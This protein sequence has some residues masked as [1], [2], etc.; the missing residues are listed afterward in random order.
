[1]KL[2]AGK[3]KLWKVFGLVHLIAIIL[4]LIYCVRTESFVKLELWSDQSYKVIAETPMGKELRYSNTSGDTLRLNL[5]PW[6]S[7][8][9][10]IAGDEQALSVDDDNVTKHKLSF[11]T[12][13][14]HYKMQFPSKNPMISIALFLINVLP[15][16][17]VYFLLLLLFFIIGIYRKSNGFKKINWLKQQLFR[18]IANGKEDL[19]S[20]PLKPLS[21]RIYQK[22]ILIA[23]IIVLIPVF[24]LNLGK[25]SFSQ[26]PEE[27]RRALVSLEMKM[28]GEYIIPTIQGEPYYKKPP[29]FNWL[30]IPFVDGDNPEGACRSV[31][32]SLLLL[33]GLV[34]FFL[35]KKHRGWQHALFVVFMYLSSM[36]VTRYL[37]F[38]L[39]LD[40]LFV[41]FL[42]PLIYLNFRYASSGR[43]YRLFIF[44]YALTSLAFLTKGIPALWV[45]FVSLMIALIINKKLKY[46]FSLPHLYGIFVLLLIIGGYFG[47]YSMQS[48]LLPYLKQFVAETLVVDMFSFKEIVAHCIS[49]PGLNMAAFMPL[50]LF[51]PLV[52]LKEN[53]HRILKSKKLSYLLLTTIAGVSVF[54]V[55]PYY[56]PYYSLMFVPVMFDVL[57]VLL[58]DFTSG[59]WKKALRA[60]LI[61]VVLIIPGF[62][63]GYINTWLVLIIGLGIYCLWRQSIN[64]LLI[65]GFVL[66]FWKGVGDMR[67][68]SDTENFILPTKEKCKQIVQDNP[69]IKLKTY[70]QETKVN[71][72]TLYYLTYFSGDIVP[73]SN[74]KPENDVYYL[75]E[76]KDM[77]EKHV[78]SDTIPQLYWTFDG[79]ERLN[80]RSKYHPVYVV[81]FKQKE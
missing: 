68:Y 29:L 62:I 37:S 5:R 66:V 20:K 70:S 11:S 71:H 10:S 17:Q 12:G 32:V 33:G 55:S 35:L 46:L 78:V 43:Y 56:L 1:M 6:K 7:I 13:D 42:V 48:D 31:S 58:P 63:T 34:I 60:Y 67:Y 51:L 69:D 28:R 25:Y 50:A 8:Q 80:G 19:S 2:F 24:Y 79:D 40:V 22:V 61:F 59:T 65:S 14:L 52:L 23:G 72:V 30:L 45:Q 36:Y 15:V 18:Y 75:I 64:V 57:L 54:W 81:K 41:L 47:L 21:L 76:Q 44:G 49:F 53:M 77:T 26:N 9:V 4:F 38:I 27:K 74:G 39:N 16:L 3:H 73:V